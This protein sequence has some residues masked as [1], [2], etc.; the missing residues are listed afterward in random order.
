MLWSL[1]KKTEA[2]VME[3]RTLREDGEQHTRAQL[4]GLVTKYDANK[5]VLGDGLTANVERG[6]TSLNS[7]PSKESES[8]N[9]Q[10]SF[11]PFPGVA[12][13]NGDNPRTWIRKCNRFFQIMTNMPKDQK[14]G[15]G[16]SSYGDHAIQPTPNP[17]ESHPIQI[18]TI[19]LNGDHFLRWSQSVRIHQGRGKIRYLTGESK[20]PD[21]EDPAY[22]IRDAENSMVMTWLVNSIVEESDA[23]TC[24]TLLRRSFGT[25]F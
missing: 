5:S 6:S 20:R 4:E 7:M 16:F 1:L 13:F 21:V 9:S 2:M 19:R 8:S 14:S 25:M 18:T 12:Y 24:A 22:A 10:S 23:N 11:N 3:E 15:I 17:S